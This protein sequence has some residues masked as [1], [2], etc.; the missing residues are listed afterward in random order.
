MMELVFEGKH[1]PTVYPSRPAEYDVKYQQGGCFLTING[2]CAGRHQKSGSDPLG[3]YCWMKINGCRD[4]GF[5]IYS[6]YRVCQENYDNPGPLTAHQ[7]EYELLRARGIVKPNPRQ[8]I[9]DDLLE[10]MEE[11]FRQGYRP[12]V[13]MDSNGDPYHQTNPDKQF[14]EFI[15]KAQLVDPFREKYPQQIRT[16]LHGN[17]RIDYILFDKVAAN[18]VKGIGYLGTHDT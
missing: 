14:L 9:L 12:I 8:Q 4:E 16:F 1:T 15:E 2:D 10:D 3:R 6:A 18:S 17:K 13:M 7:G 5:V 11:K